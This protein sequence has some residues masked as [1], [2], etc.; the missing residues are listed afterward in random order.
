MAPMRCFVWRVIVPVAFIMP[1]ARAGS[2]GTMFEALQTDSRIPLVHS[3][4][5]SA[6]ASSDAK[7]NNSWSIGD[8]AGFTSMSD[9]SIEGVVHEAV[10]ATR[11]STGAAAHLVQHDDNSCSNL[12]LLINAT[13]EGVFLQGV[14][15]EWVPVIPISDA[16]SAPAG[17]NCTLSTNGL[18]LFLMLILLRL[19]TR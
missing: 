9:V 16:A 2:D 10:F 15:K 12:S 1:Q 18:W 8:P 14:A 5:A 11:N 3:Y 4:D 6:Q 17:R 19:L 7:Q 13:V